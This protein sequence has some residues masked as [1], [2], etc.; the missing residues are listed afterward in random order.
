MKFDILMRLVIVHFPPFLL[1]IGSY[2]A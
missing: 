2:W 1:V